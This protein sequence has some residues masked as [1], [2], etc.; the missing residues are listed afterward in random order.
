MKNV[1]NYACASLV[2]VALLF[3]PG[4]INAEASSTL[5]NVENEIV[6]DGCTSEVDLTLENGDKVHI[7]GSCNSVRRQ[8]KKYKKAGLIK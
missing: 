4:A 5:T 2:A 1:K 7:E 3:T 8:V 6:F